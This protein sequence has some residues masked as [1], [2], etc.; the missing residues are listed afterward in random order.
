MIRSFY[1]IT[2][3]KVFSFFQSQFQCF[4]GGSFYISQQFNYYKFAMFTECMFIVIEMFTCFYGVFFL[5][6]SCD[7]LF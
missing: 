5:C 3:P 7:Y 2:D 6:L 1:D 4:G